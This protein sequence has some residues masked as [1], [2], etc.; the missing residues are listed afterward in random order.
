MERFTQHLTMIRK[1][2]RIKY[3]DIEAHTR[4]PAEKLRRV[5]EGKSNFTIDELEKL[6]RYYQMT[7]DQVLKYKRF[8]LSKWMLAVV[9]AVFIG[10]TG[11]SAYLFWPG[12]GT[13]PVQEA[14]SL[15]AD[16]QAAPN[17]Q[18]AT[19][20]AHENVP[21]PEPDEQ[22]DTE[23]THSNLETNT[24]G[25]S[26]SE[27]Q[28][29]AELKQ[30]M[31]RFWGNIPYNTPILPQLE[32]EKEHTVLDVI[33]IE[34]LSTTKP[35]W[36][37]G[38]DKHQVILNAGTAD[39]W[40]PTTIEAFRTLKEE[41]YNIFGLGATPRVYEPF[42][43]KIN[44]KKIGFLSLAGLIHQPSEIALDKKI[45]L[46]R[47]YRKDETLKA[48]REAKAK[49]DYLFVLIDWGR[50][51]S[52]THNNTQKAIA[53]SIIHGGGDF[54]VGNHPI[55]SQDFEL[56]EGKP[57]FYGLGHSVYSK[58]DENSVNF[59]LEAEFTSQLDKVSLRAGQMKKGILTF[60]LTSDD[61]KQV[62]AALAEKKITDNI[63]QEY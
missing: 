4:I 29:S 58:A 9:C 42:I 37:Q 11:V 51:W 47:A 45:G 31:F 34:Q 61:R 44:S 7:F 38:K 1:H 6:L 22:T 2:K 52:E 18:P 62:Q 26:E 36:L 49:V 60:D 5:E 28:A 21:E 13:E 56:I 30:V 54:I 41:K 17:K 55:Y 16:V 50:A 57:V 19:E 53:E 43:M 24:E 32:V 27:V 46:A 23:V 33:P 8:R 10:A 12:I 35:V 15:H 3:S 25:K 59:V 39:I 63:E 48:V 40:T 20:V 14:T